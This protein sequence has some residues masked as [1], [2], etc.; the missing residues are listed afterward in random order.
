MPVIFMHT[1]SIP[2]DQ[3]LLGDLYRTTRYVRVLNTYLCMFGF[4]LGPMMVLFT[5]YTL[6]HWC[7]CIFFVCFILPPSCSVYLS[8]YLVCSWKHNILVT[9]GIFATS[10]L[11]SS[12][13]IRNWH[14]RWY[15][16][17]SSRGIGIQFSTSNN[18]TSLYG[19]WLVYRH[20]AK[21]SRFSHVDDDT[22]R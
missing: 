5:T 12:K 19:H 16:T 3:Y 17:S 2:R 11:V 14:E 8:M 20:C 9:P 4:F 18:T 13:T 15:F 1:L 10:L 21:L 22:L 7:Q 6:A